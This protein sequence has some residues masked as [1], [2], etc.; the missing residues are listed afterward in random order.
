MERWPH[1]HFERLFEEDRKSKCWVWNG[2]LNGNGLPSFKPTIDHH[3]QKH[4]S[5]ASF[6][7]KFYVGPMPTG[8]VAMRKCPTL[9]CVNPKHRVVTTRSE[10]AR[11]RHANGWRPKPTVIDNLKGYV[12]LNQDGELN[13][14]AKL[15]DAQRDEL[16][17][18]VL[19][20][21]KVDKI[22]AEFNVSRG[23]VFRLVKV[24]RTTWQK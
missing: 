4:L 1:Q 8:M 17:R 19:A 7:Y 14:Q 23:H 15:K 24:R 22:A 12:G 13:P 6:A 18:R 21:E 11:I 5:A 16:V 9:L 2:P 20:G 3:R 10:L